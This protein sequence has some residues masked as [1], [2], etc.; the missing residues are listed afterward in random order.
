MLALV[1]VL[2]TEQ[3]KIAPNQSPFL[4][5]PSHSTTIAWSVLEAH[6]LGGSG[7]LQ[8][9]WANPSKRTKPQDAA[10]SR[11]QGPAGLSLV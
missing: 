9:H 6:E 11:R 4:N 8:E 10:G 1:G 5:K 7:Q 3:V 2:L